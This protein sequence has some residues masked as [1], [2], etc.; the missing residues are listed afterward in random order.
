MFRILLIT[1]AVLSLVSLAMGFTG[2]WLA[3]GESLA[4]FRLPNLLVVCLC[5]PV[6][7]KTKYFYA[8]LSLIILSLLSVAIH[9]LPQKLSSQDTYRLYQKNLSYRLQNTDALKADILS[10]KADFIALQE[11]TQNNRAFITD[12]QGHF[13]YQATCPYASIGGVSVMSRW[14]DMGEREC[15]KG[16]SAI[17]I[18][19]PT[20]PLWVISVH[21]Y[22]PYPYGQA[23]QVRKLT[24]QIYALKG[25]KIIAGDFNMVPWSYTLKSFERASDTQTARPIHSFD[26]PYI[27]MNIP[28]DHV[29]VP[30]GINAITLRREKKGS[31][32]YGVLAEFNRS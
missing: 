14:P 32:H 28:I 22:W 11:V 8:A 10:T 24:K 25:P 21:L 13:P 7:R 15:V 5:L 4:V 20:G 18:K 6:I 3:L 30:S 2:R 19:T 31:D 26:L 1:I 12:L 29:L 17:K 16:M 23:E 27:P 9:Y